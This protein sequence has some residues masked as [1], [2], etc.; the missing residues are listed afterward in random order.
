MHGKLSVLADSYDMQECPIRLMTQKRH[1]KF[2][3]ID[4][5]EQSSWSRHLDTI[6]LS[7][8]VQ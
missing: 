5:V 8:S 2:H 1:D 4:I 7:I 3:P 6:L